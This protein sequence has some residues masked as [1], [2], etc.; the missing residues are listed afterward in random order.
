MSDSELE[1]INNNIKFE[2]VS[3]HLKEKIYESCRKDLTGKFMDQG[4]C[5][6]CDQVVTLENMKWEKV[7]EN[8]VGKCKEKLIPSSELS[9]ELVKYYDI[10][11]FIPNLEGV[12]LSP[13]TKIVFQDVKRNSKCPLILVCK[14]CVSSLKKKSK[15][16]YSSEV[17]HSQW[18]R[19]RKSSRLF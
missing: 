10:S 13:K 7:S 3:D 12:L 18:F 14:P 15:K 2:P 19:N 9:S 4:V 5:S 16:Q 6:I 1:D 17:F 8:L 11:K